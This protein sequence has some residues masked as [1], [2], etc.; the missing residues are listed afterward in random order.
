MDDKSQYQFL[1]GALAMNATTK[2]SYRKNLAA[3]GLIFLNG[4]EREVSVNNLSMTGLL[5]EF[6]HAADAEI[7]NQSLS[8]IGKVID[9]YLPDLHLAGTSEIVR[10]SHEEGQKKLALK[11]KDIAY[12][13]DN[14]LYKR[15][16]Y[17][18]TLS[19]QGRITFDDK[20]Y[21]FQTVNV[22]V[23]GLMIRLMSTAD[24]QEG[25]SAQFEFKDLSLKGEVSVVWVDANNEGKTL[26][27]LKYVNINSEQIKGIPRFEV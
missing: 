8:L 2:R 10:I 21:L 17:R 26:V 22:S 15:K 24:I 14:L 12:N 3:H 6:V 20:C 19:V 5:V 27:G 9:F 18:K 11:F 25:M 23:E 16:V 13:I 4:A 1:V 7:F